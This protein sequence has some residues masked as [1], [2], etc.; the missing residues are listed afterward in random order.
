M[1]INLLNNPDGLAP[2]NSD[3]WF[4]VNSG[5]SSVSNFKYIFKINNKLEP[6][7][8]GSIST[9][10]LYKVPP[11]P[12][13]GDGLFSPSNLLK[14]Y[15]GYDIEANKS[16]WGTHSAA[17]IEYYIDY[18]FEYNPDLNFTD[19]FDVSGNLGLTF[20]TPHGL[21]AGD[22]ITIDKDNKTQNLN[23]DGT[24]SVLST[25]NDWSIETDKTYGLVINDET[26]TIINL[27]RLS[28]TSS[29][30]YA[31]NGTR[32]YN[33]RTRDFEDEYVLTGST[34]SFLTNYTGTYKSVFSDNWETISMILDNTI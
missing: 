22:L 30:Y 19:T 21:T 13:N 1:I 11:R 12:I 20:S 33:E 26:G 17:L 7:D 16:S 3:L 23:Y 28:L 24:A 32:Q 25:P 31:F 8:T 27:T 6:F 10:S 18:G 34:S 2:V 9:S 29:N 4:R 5:S 14:S 15:I